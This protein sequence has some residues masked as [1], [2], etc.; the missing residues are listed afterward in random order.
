MTLCFAVCTLSVLQNSNITQQTGAQSTFGIPFAVSCIIGHR[1]KGSASND[2][3]TTTIQCNANGL[4]DPT[5]ICEPKG[6]H[7]H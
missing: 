6:K 5:P 7:N 3:V 2:N 1:F 4:F